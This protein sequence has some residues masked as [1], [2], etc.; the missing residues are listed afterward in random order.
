MP[1][2][3]R[4]TSLQKVHSILDDQ[5]IYNSQITHPDLPLG[6]DGSDEYR[7]LGKAHPFKTLLVQ[8]LGP[9]M[10]NFFTALNTMIIS[11][12]VT[13]A[14]PNANAALSAITIANIPECIANAFAWALFIG[15]SC[16]VGRYLGAGDIRSAQAAA[17]HAFV[18]G[19]SGSVGLLLIL[20][21][22]VKPLLKS[23]SSEE[24][25]TDILDLALQYIVVLIFAVPITTIYFLLTGIAA[26]SGMVT[27]VTVMAILEI[28]LTL[29]L[30]CPL[31]LFVVKPLGIAGASLGM[32]TSR[33]LL[34]CVYLWFYIKKMTVR[35]NWKLLCGYRTTKFIREVLSVG[36]IDMISSLSATVILGIISSYIAQLGTD[37]A[38]IYYENSTPEVQKSIYEEVVASWGCLNRVYSMAVMISFGITGGYLPA[39]SYA[40]G[41]KHYK[42]FIQLTWYCFAYDC[43]ALLLFSI[44]FIIVIPWFCKV[45]SNTETYVELSIS[46]VRIML[47]TGVILPFQFIITTICQ[48][49]LMTLVG[50][51]LGLTTQVALLPLSFIIIYYA[52]RH[53]IL[54]NVK[55]R[56]NLNMLAFT[57]ND[58]LSAIVSLGVWC[59]PMRKYKQ[60]AAEQEALQQHA[61]FVPTSQISHSQPA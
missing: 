34:S 54:A 9:L 4:S 7:R 15:C 60:L 16:T 18:L 48:A 59:V 43:A 40:L 28:V 21:F 50:I 41:R 49:C 26:G 24:Y 56:I 10:F 57:F 36:I 37:Y 23:T 61:S 44:V 5:A 6:D 38:K 33:L 1:Q 42:R 14:L 22:T 12:Y 3:T 46:T 32:V 2:A 55:L 25:S 39:A 17:I 19:L 8:S 53:F 51:I 52:C 35:M 45:F 58:I 11:V 31:Y 27:L 20:L 29:G 13:K 30:F 47:A